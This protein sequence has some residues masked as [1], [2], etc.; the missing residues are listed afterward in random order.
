MTPDELID[1][2]VSTAAA[3]IATARLTGRPSPLGIGIYPLHGKAATLLGEAMPRLGERMAKA[4]GL[5]PFTYETISPTQR[6]MTLVGPRQRGKETGP[7]WIQIELPEQGTDPGAEGSPLW[8]LGSYGTPKEHL[9]IPLNINE[10]ELYE[11]VM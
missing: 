4:L 7:D 3:G 8:I 9:C 11:T 6:Y 1:R 10:D 5:T 2:I